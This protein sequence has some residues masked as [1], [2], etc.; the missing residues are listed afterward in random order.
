METTIVPFLD[1]DGKPLQYIA[2]RADITERKEAE[3]KFRE[4]EVETKRAR[5][6]AEATLRTAP[7]PLLILRAD[8]RVNTA[9]EAFYKN[10]QVAPAETEGTLIYDLGNRQWNIPKLRELLEEI[11]PKNNFFN[12][13]EIT[14]E[15][16]TIGRRTMLLNA[17]R[18]EN[19][20][21][22]PLQIVLAIEDITARRQ[23]EK[24][25]IEAKEHAEAA[26]KAKDNFLAAL[27][28]E[29]RTP[30]T[31]VLMT[32]TALALDPSLPAEARE[33]LDMMRR[34]IELEARLID[35]LLDLTRIIHGKLIITPITTDIH[36]LIL[37]THEIIRSDSLIKRLHITLKLEATRHHTLGDPARLQQVFWNLLR[38]AVKFT[39]N[40]GTITVST[41]NDAEGRI[42]ICV[43]DN[44]I[45]IRAEVLAQIFDAF[46]QADTTGEHHYGGLGLG[47]AISSAIV[48]AHGGEIKAESQGRRHG[49]EFTVTLGSV[50]P[51][52]A[53]TSKPHASPAQP[54]LSLSL[55]VVED[56]EATRSVL[57]RL[58]TRSGHLV[59]TAATVN[60]ALTAYKAAHF[61]VVISDLGLPDGSGIDLMV[62]IQHIRPV[63]AIALSGF[64]M[65]NDLQRSKEAGFFAHL[66][67]PV[68]MD[69]IKHLLTQIP[70]RS[71]PLDNARTNPSIT[72]PTP[73][74][75]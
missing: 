70:A 44:G 73:P 43:A 32:A 29:L 26:S 64:G 49:A 25:L 65:E 11:L 71:E 67:K 36:D 54:A 56:H 21:G 48:I 72:H 51:A 53:A 37:H 39:P 34:N 62:Q 75:P 9:N 31:P 41:H 69:Q 13:F 4:N 42:I 30:L 14:H 46:E 68:K 61:D 28:H 52:L 60:D 17:R 6:Y 8:L 57:E 24:A 38:N 20:A 12:D 50:L 47:L 27:S 15:F 40:G 35:D 59:V 66:V 16:E 18:M 55:L 5:D 3:E 10:F 74:S 58:L 22:L 1:E 19:E 45:G 63:P 7:V 33:Q 2:I 23:A